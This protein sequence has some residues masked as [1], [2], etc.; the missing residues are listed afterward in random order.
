VRG[1]FITGTGTGVGKT[2]VAGAIAAVL[3]ARGERVAAH[4]P[5]LTGVDDH[6]D[7]EPADHEVLAAITGQTPAA[8]AP[9]R[10]GPAVSPHLAAA[11]AATEIDP[12]AL[13][14]AARRAGEG[15]DA[16]VVEGVGG[17]LVPLAPGYCVR[18]LARELALPVV[19]AASSGLGTINH[20]LLTLE[21]A[22]A[23]GLNVR[24]VV[25]SPW[26]QEPSEMERSNAETIA[27]VGAVDIAY[28]PGVPEPNP[29]QLA[30]AGASLPVG[31]WLRS[32]RAA[33]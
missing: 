10:F 4:K 33:V 6:V 20:S 30:H 16:L 3:V 32:D 22:R 19:I 23:A 21:A 24:A 11:L 18:D 27:A 26:P 28:L 5:A 12:D 7:G 1:V 31:A 2:Y 17:L 8:V 14:T 13:V 29:E 15:A 9:L 25:L